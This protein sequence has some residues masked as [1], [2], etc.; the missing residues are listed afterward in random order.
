MQILY[1]QKHWQIYKWDQPNHLYA[2]DAEAVPI[3]QVPDFVLKTAL[4]GA[5]LIG[6][7][8]YGIDL[9]EINHKA[10]LIE[11]NDNPNVDYGVEDEI[12]G[13]NYILTLC[14]IFG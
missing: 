4:K 10:Y 6:D 12:L 3:N 11:I 7:G 2:G 13:K 5:N 1:G 14:D 9:K 8:F